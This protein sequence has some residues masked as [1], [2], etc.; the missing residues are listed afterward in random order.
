MT[1]ETSRLDRISVVLH[2]TIALGI[3]LMIPFGHKIED[4]KPSPEKW[5]MIANHKSIGLAVLAL[6]VWRLVR[7]FRTGFASP[8]GP[9]KRIERVLAMAVHW[10]LLLLPILIPLAGVAASI[11]G[12]HPVGFF[13]VPVIPQLPQ[14]EAKN[15]AAAAHAA[16]GALGF[17]IVVVLGLHVAGA[18]K[19]QFIYR[20]GTLKRMLGSTV[21]EK[22]AA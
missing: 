21:S 8:L 6:A 15:W 14:T 17:L 2:W 20:D 11:A 19:H 10:I 3:F 16:H 5:Q 12:A 22:T 18:L 9:D 4:M 1:T 7:H 13:G